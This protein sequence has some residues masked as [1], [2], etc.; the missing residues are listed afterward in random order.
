MGNATT[1]STLFVG[2]TYA[3]AGSAAAEKLQAL[4]ESPFDLSD[5]SAERLA[6]MYA[7]AGGYKL[8]Y[9][10]QRVT[11]EVMGALWELAEEARVFEKMEAMQAGETINFIEGHESE[12]RSVLHTAVRD[13]FD[14]PNPAPA[15]AEA[16][17]KA[18]AEFDKLG[19]FIDKIG[20]K[21]TDLVCIG[22][23]GS[24]LGPKMLYFG[25]QGHAR[26]DRKIHFVSN[27]DPDDA[28]QAL[29]G[30]DLEKTLVITVSKSGGTLE[31]KTNEDLVRAHFEKAGVQP[32]QHFLVATGEGSPMDDPNRYLERF[33]IWDWIGGRYC[34]TSVIGGIVLAFAYGMD[35]YKEFLHGAHEMDRVALERDPKKNLPLLMALL[36]IWNRNFLGY[37]TLA[38]I[39][40]AQM[41]VRF[42]AHIQ[43]LDMESDGKR[44]DRQ[45]EPV[46]FHTGPIVWG[47]PATNAQHSF[48]QLIH[49]GTDVI[50]LEF[51][52]FAKTQMGDD[53]EQGGVTSQEK[54]VA[55]MFAQ[56]LALAMG[57]E[58]GNPNKVFPGQ[59]PSSLLL[60]ERLTPRALGALLALYEH[61]V[62]F[63]G[64]IWNINSFDQE[65]VQLGKVL[66]NQIIE[67][68]GS[69][70]KGEGEPYPLG[71]AL[72]DHL[73][74]R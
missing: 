33:Y 57:Q 10:S 53:L 3:F 67:R 44:I 34:A 5:L 69:R 65:G 49:Q 18:R 32:E 24:E 12:H 37:P 31:T 25:L 16:T 70:K 62:A 35:V 6:K 27:V 1:D 60:A 28:A 41:L 2:G 52:G 26:P 74:M 63:Q 73:G 51:I 19:A 36:G 47:E 55:N 56:A 61:K 48:F 50:P 45:G 46:Q 14:H 7:E 39:P 29:R 54:L 43:Q 58:S 22:I 38:I 30:L 68:I 13:F 4:A 72:L 23:G 11:D 9:G 64:F 40:Y 15:A 17:A 71:D 66:A 20:D 21:F 59:R 42:A 8:V